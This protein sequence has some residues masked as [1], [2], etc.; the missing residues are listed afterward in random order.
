MMF[1][2]F[3]IYLINF[4]LIILWIILAILAL[5]QLRRPDLP[6]TARALWAIL[7]VAIPL[8]GAI[9]FWIVNPGTHLS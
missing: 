1:N 3:P 6:E 4:L 2:M 9:A 7:I 5:V 8:G